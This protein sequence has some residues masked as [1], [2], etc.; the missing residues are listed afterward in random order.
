MKSLLTYCE[1]ERAWLVDT[2]LSLV[3]CE[4][5]TLDKA[6]VD[7]CGR[8][9]QVQLRALGGRV[10]VLQRA[11]AGDHVLAEF[12]CGDRQVLLLG[13]HDTVWPTGELARQPARAEQGRLYGPGVYDMKAGL[14]LALLA[15]RALQDGPDGLPGRIALLSTSDEETGSASSRAAIEDEAQ[16]SAAVLVLEP[17]LPDGGV[18]T[19]RKGCGQYLVRVRGVAAHAG[20]EPEKGASAVHELARQVDSALR[21]ADPSRGLTVN[22]GTVR[23]CTRP[24][25]VAEAAEAEIDV[26]VSSLEDAARVD[27]AIRALRP[28]D[29]RTSIDVAGGIDRPPMERSAAVLHL[30]E[31]ARGVAAQLGRKIGRASCRERV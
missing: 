23:G 1:S 9:L 26:R 12:G 19:W 10:Q 18:K 13:H 15:V 28:H 6:A 21:L 3:R 27:R 2:T 22:V 20:V 7:E 5:P 4:S 31:H 14:A 30:Y 17:A 25:V 11:G 29:A 8:A 16:R 24:N